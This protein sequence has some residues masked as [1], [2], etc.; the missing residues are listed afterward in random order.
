[1]RQ[2]SVRSVTKGSTDGNNRL[3]GESRTERLKIRFVGSSQHR[4]DQA[5][6]IMR[7]ATAAAKRLNKPSRGTNRPRGGTW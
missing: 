3:H 4:S 2:E 5:E 7:P 1:M 6:A